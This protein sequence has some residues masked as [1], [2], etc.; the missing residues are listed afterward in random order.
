MP[1]KDNLLPQEFY[2]ALLNFDR[3]CYGTKKCKIFH[4]KNIK[5]EK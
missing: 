1:E 4:T 3:N 2:V 5:K